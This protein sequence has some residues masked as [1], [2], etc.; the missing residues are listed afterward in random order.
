[1]RDVVAIDLRERAEAV[2]VV[3]A[4]VLQP[5]GRLVGGVEKLVIGDLGGHGGRKEAQE[6][7]EEWEALDHW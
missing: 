2:A 1:M 4:G 7:K 5:V 3:G 6:D